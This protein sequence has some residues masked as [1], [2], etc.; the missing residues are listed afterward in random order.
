MKHWKKK[1]AV[2]CGKPGTR[3]VLKK[4]YFAERIHS[5]HIIL[6][7]PSKTFGAQIHLVLRTDFLPATITE[8]KRN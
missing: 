3:Q 6:L 5:C 7:I 1:S 2:K 4:A 8:Y